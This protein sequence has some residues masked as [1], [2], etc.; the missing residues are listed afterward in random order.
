MLGN[1][2]AQLSLLLAG[3]ICGTLAGSAVLANVTPVIQNDAERK[4]AFQR[5]HNTQYM[6]EGGYIDDGDYTLLD[7]LPRAD[8]SRGGVYFIG[9]SEM[10]ISIMP[11]TLPPAERALIHNF[12]IGDLRF[13]ELRR[14]MRTLVEDHNLL[15]AGGEK[16]TIFLGITY[17]LA[18]LKDLKKE[19]DRYVMNLF[20]RHGLYTY[21]WEKGIHKVDQPAA[22]RFFRLQRDCADRF[23]RAFFVKKNPP[24]HIDPPKVFIQH[25]TGVM[26]EAWEKTMRAEVRELEEMLDYLKAKNV[27]L[28]AI[29]GPNAPWQDELPYDNAFRALVL[30]LLEARGIPVID[31]RDLLA[32][33]DFGDAVHA[34]YSGQIKLHDA[35]RKLALEA[36]E[37]MG[38]ELKEP[39]GTPDE[40]VFGRCS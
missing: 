16:T 25:L 2:Q 38:T 19:T 35:Y 31:H 15:Q 29:I 39:S 34:R 21:D 26:G 36:L 10:K 4:L 24:T 14:Y 27:R 3:A 33:D 11:W 12:S 17:Q 13:R 6:F 7:Q 23:V 9:A 20:E 37:E 32:G 30:P 5:E 18:R 28:R 1:R 22:E 40:V 8:L